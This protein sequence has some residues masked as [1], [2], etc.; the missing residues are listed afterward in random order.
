MISE[1]VSIWALI[2]VTAV[3]PIVLILVARYFRPK[4]TYLEIYKF[5][6]SPEGQAHKQDVKYV[7]FVANCIEREIENAHKRPKWTTTFIKR[8]RLLKRTRSSLE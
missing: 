1:T 3:T 4:A 2:I 8:K 5:F 6:E 7:D